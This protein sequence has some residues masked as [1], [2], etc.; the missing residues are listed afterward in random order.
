M[1]IFNKS[2]HH[3]QLHDKRYDTLTTLEF[4]LLHAL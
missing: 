3:Q 1:L 2:L 4:I